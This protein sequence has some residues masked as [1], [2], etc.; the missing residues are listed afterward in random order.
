MN[1]C[2]HGLENPYIFCLSE[3]RL[4]LKKYLVWNTEMSLFVN[5]SILCYDCTLILFT[6]LVCNMYRYVFMKMLCQKWQ[7]IPVTTNEATLLCL[8]IV[9]VCVDMYAYVCLGGG[10]WGSNNIH[11]TR[12]GEHRPETVGFSETW[13]AGGRD[14]QTR[15]HGWLCLVNGIL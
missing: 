5:N 10:G 4:Y 1:N 2:F 6:L 15:R 3:G 13:W 14:R 8:C 7:N 12:P 9:Y 11:E